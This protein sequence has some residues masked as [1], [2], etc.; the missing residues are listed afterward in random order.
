MNPAEAVAD[1]LDLF[2]L[3]WVKDPSILQKR[4]GEHGLSDHFTLEVSAWCAEIHGQ[5]AELAELAGLD[6]LL[7]G[8]NG[9]ALRMDVSAQR[10]SRDNDYLTTAKE[11]ELRALM[12][13]LRDRFAA[14]PEP[15]FTSERHPP[16]EG[17]KP[18][19][20]VSYWVRGCPRPRRTLNGGPP[21]PSAALGSVLGA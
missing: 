12:R 16:P 2:K 6:L 18:L 10:G 3:D 7:M 20:L 13:A 1:H 19:P 17:A 21:A 4:A 5:L 15:L 9:T 14:L 11:S 8:G